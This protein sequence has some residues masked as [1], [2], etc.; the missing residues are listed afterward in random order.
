MPGEPHKLQLD[1]QIEEYVATSGDAMIQQISENKEVALYKQYT[2][3]ALHAPRQNETATALYQLLKVI[4]IALDNR[5]K[6][7]DML[8]F[9]DLYSHG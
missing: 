3:N 1:T 9:S 8:C 2:I 4:E 7:L 6:Y 5:T